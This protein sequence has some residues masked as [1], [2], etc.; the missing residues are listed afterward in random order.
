[1]RPPPPPT[2]TP[3]PPA[4]PPWRTEGLFSTHFLTQRLAAP[5]SA[6]WPG[7]AAAGA[8]FE[9]L[10]DLYARTVVGPRKGDEEDCEKRFITPALDLA[11]FAADVGYEG[12]PFGR[13]EERRLH[14]RCQ[15]D[16]LFFILY[17]LSRAEAA[18]ILDTFPIVRRHDEARWGRFRTKDLILAYHN[19]LAAGDLAGWV[20]G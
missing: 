14:L 8:V 6:P 12:P 2:T 20:K 15:L 1:M 7:G 17:G 9:R 16:A 5:G 3:P 11:G 18:E 13:D 10:L 19:A 4:A